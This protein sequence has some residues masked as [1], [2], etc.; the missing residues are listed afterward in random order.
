MVRLP[1]ARGDRR[2]IG[3]YIYY[4]GIVS[5]LGSNPVGLDRGQVG[6]PQILRL[7]ELGG[8]V[9]F[10]LVNLRF[11]AS[12]RVGGGGAGGRGVVRQLRDLERRNRRAR[13]RR[14]TADRSRSVPPA[15]RARHRRP[16]GR[17]RTGRLRLRPREERHRR[18]RLP[19]LPGQPRVRVAAHLHR[20]EARRR[21][22]RVSPSSRVCSPSSSISRSC[23]CPTRG[24]APR[25][26]DPRMGSFAISVPGL[27]RAARELDRTA[28]DRAPPAGEDRSLGRSARSRRCANR[29]STTSTG[30]RRSRSAARSSRAPAGGPRRSRRRAS[31][32]RFRVELLPEG[33]D[34]LDLRYNVIQWVH[35]ATRGW[36]YGGG[37]VDPRT[38][39][40]LKGHVTLGSLR[41]RQDRLLFEGLA[42]AAKSGT[43]LPD[44]PV[45]LALAR[46][47]QLAAHEV[48]HALGSLAQLRRQRLRPRLG[49]GLSRAAR[50][51]QRPGRARLLAG[52]RRRS[53]G[54]GRARDAL[55]LSRSFR[56]APTS[57]PRSTRSC[58]PDCSGNL[59]FLTDDDARPAGAANPRASLWDN[60]DDPVAALEQT[61]RVRRIALARFGEANLRAGE[62]LALLEETARPGLLPSSL[63]APGGGQGGRRSR[64]PLRL[65]RRR[66]SR[67]PGPRRSRRSASGGRSRSCSRRSTRRCSICPT[68]PCASSC[69]G[70]TATR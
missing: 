26:F 48:G 34:P 54:V 7:R 1:P 32:T 44:D 38:G 40:Q 52:L 42:G 51:D 31:R 35:R 23:A 66:R 58:S 4:E 61:M 6:E 49:H 47:R 53:R 63:P 69:R 30:R 15:R 62:P 29:S 46:I 22:A 67:S 57:R 21:G 45:V 12:D 36:S 64:L 37:V 25:E 14:R 59:Y 20:C 33:A 28:L 68:R 50:A 43:G 18:R 65:E 70:R 41:V 16:P 27:R 9:L 13:R 2:T 10:E 19:R 39:E 11:R 3:E 5:G 24:Y 56:R 60:G 17:E 55:G 8:R